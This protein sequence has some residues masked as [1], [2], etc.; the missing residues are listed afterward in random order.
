MLAVG[1]SLGRYRIEGKL[2][3]G[4][5]GTV[6]RAHDPTLKRE[7]A[8]KVLGTDEGSLLPD[9]EAKARF[10]REA[11]SAAGLD[12]PNVVAVYDVGEIDGQA[13]LAMEL[14]VGA[15]LRSLV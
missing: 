2:G 5:M 11:R 4:A 9:D 10:F 13:Y 8:L 1:Q 6:Y 3:Q 14:V 15:S 7:V 12:Q